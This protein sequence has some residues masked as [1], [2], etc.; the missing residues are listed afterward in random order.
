MRLC[1]NGASLRGCLFVVIHRHIFWL[2]CSGGPARQGGTNGSHKLG[3]E[4]KHFFKSNNVI[5]PN[6]L[7][8]KNNP[9]TSHVSA[10]MLNNTCYLRSRLGFRTCKTNQPLRRGPDILS[11]MILFINWAYQL[12]LLK[13]TYVTMQMSYVIRETDDESTQ[14]YYILWRYGSQI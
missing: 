7:K 2:V 9:K 13:K 1:Q 5:F 14:Q 12:V 11:T 4:P 3:Y 10:V 6:Y 8:P